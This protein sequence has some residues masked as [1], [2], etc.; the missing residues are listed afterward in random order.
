M[1]YD[2]RGRVR[3]IQTLLACS[4]NL[5]SLSLFVYRFTSPEN[6]P[7]PNLEVQRIYPIYGDFSIVMSQMRRS[8]IDLSTAN[9]KAVLDQPRSGSLF[10]RETK[11]R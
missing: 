2:R 4:A 6:S 11:P 3:Y 8:T 7:V 1:G 9:S 10:R 5:C